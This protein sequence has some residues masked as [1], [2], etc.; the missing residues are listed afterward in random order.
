MLPTACLFLF[1]LVWQ[2]FVLNPL[3]HRSRIGSS[4]LCF[5]NQ[6]C[7]IYFFVYRVMSSV[8]CFFCNFLLL[9]LVVL[10]LF[11]FSRVVPIAFNLFGSI[12][13]CLMIASLSIVRVNHVL[14]RDERE[15]PPL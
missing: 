1:D 11:Y 6:C 14:R 10:R 4:I 7:R 5:F 2:A 12:Y 9:W 13:R 15:V 3:D 8:L